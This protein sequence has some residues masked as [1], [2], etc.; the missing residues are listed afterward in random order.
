MFAVVLLC[1]LK[2]IYMQYIEFGGRM[3]HISYV[4]LCACKVTLWSLQGYS[5]VDCTVCGKEWD[6]VPGEAD[7][8]GTEE[9][10]V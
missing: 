1:F 9:L 7:A 6:F 8:E 3:R 10:P 2:I 5:K 4:C